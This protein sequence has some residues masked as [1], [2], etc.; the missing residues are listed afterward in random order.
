MESNEEIIVNTEAEKLEY[1]ERLLEI[2]KLRDN[3]YDEQR[4]IEKI[5]GLRDF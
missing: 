1:L 2:K 5:L 4:S 3:L